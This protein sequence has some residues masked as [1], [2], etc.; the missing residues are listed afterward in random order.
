[1]KVIQN[2]KNTSKTHQIR[3]W[4]GELKTLANVWGS[5]PDTSGRSIGAP[6]A[7]LPVSPY[8]LHFPPNVRGCRINTAR[9]E[10][11]D[12]GEYT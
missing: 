10:F 1:M 9:E 3:L 12:Q 8:R 11:L 5:A 7:P 4:L 2:A 6:Q